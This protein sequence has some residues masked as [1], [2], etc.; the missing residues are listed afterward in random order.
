MPEGDTVWRAAQRLNDVLAGRELVSTDFRVPSLA[1]ADVSGFR[2]SEV[3]SAGKHL[4]FRMNRGDDRLTLHTHFRIDGS[5][6]IYPCG[7]P[8]RG[9]PKDTIR[10]V[11]RT[12]TH[13]VV[14]YRLPVVELLPRNDEHSV[15]GHLGIDIMSQQW[16]QALAISA[17]QSHPERAIGD[18]LL[19]QR[20][21]AGIGNLY[22]CEAL[23]ICSTNP[24]IPV[25]EADAP[26]IVSTVAR[27]MHRNRWNPRQV[28]TGDERRGREHFVH[29]RSGRSC[30][31]CGTR[32]D[33]GRDGT[34]PR[35]RLVYWCPRCQA[36]L[37]Q[38]LNQS[39]EAGIQG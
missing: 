18:A 14:G 26:A 4:L 35:E 5:W 13:D 24:W 32:I 34:A 17:L 20:I 21:I 39:G 1:T 11:L 38:G 2:V 6:H 36:R 9:G 31:R 25:E 16:D 37:R 3:A 19:D 29:A 15:V 30:R 8:W 28:T 12:G 27:L 10:V 23:F 22:R 33:I 7:E